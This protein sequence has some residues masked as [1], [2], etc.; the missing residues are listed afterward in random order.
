MAIAI[1]GATFVGLGGP[2]SL[3]AT[4]QCTSTC[5]SQRGAAQWDAVIDWGPGILVRDLAG[6]PICPAE[7]ELSHAALIPRGPF[8]GCVL[9]YRKE[10]ILDPMD[11]NQ[12]APNCGQNSSITWIFDPNGADP[13]ALI[14]LEFDFESDIFCG[15]QSWD[16]WGQLVVAGGVPAGCDTAMPPPFPPQTYRFRPQGLSGQVLTTTEPTPA[17]PTKCPR[18][19]LH[20]SA[21]WVRVGDMAIARYYATVMPLNAD[22]LL[23]SNN[24]VPTPGGTIE[25]GTNLVAGGPP[26]AAQGVGNEFWEVLKARKTTTATEWED[27]FVPISPHVEDPG[28]NYLGN[29]APHF[30]PDVHTAYDVYPRAPAFP[31]AN[32]PNRLLDS[33]PR[34]FQMSNGEILVCGDVDTGGMG[35]PVNAPGSTWVIQPRYSAGNPHWVLADG[36]EPAPPAGESKWHDSWYDSAVLLQLVNAITGQRKPDRV[37]M[38]GGSRDDAGNGTWIVNDEV[39]EFEPTGSSSMTLGNWR[40]KVSPS[41]GEEPQFVGSSVF[42]SFKRVYGNAIIL[43]TGEIFLVGGT[44]EEDGGAGSSHCAGATAPVRPVIYDPGNAPLDRGI[45]YEMPLNVHPRL[46]HSTATLLPDGRVL[47]A[48]G[49]RAKN[50]NGPGDC[51]TNMSAPDPKQTGQLFSPPYLD[52]ASSGFSSRPIVTLDVSTISIGGTFEIEVTRNCN[53][54]IDRVVLLRPGATTHH[55]DNDQ[56]Y[57]ELYYSITTTVPGGPNEEVDTIL[58]TAPGNS[59]LAP[60]GYYMLFAIESDGCIDPATGKEILGHR[61]PSVAQFIRLD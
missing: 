7:F 17:C 30:D 8:A 39:W 57:V 10:I 33:Y 48:G 31:D 20:T 46:Y 19:A 22:Q 45:V 44:S 37:L 28:P 38:F 9:L 54:S 51:P 21:P 50:F 49:K 52:L 42:S 32:Y 2:W 1:C 27:P 5:T 6:N 14:G 29:N 12:C 56:R 36:Q 25:G 47:V 18:A 35:P 40:R 61:V 59:L 4:A 13:A 26:T 53:R 60:Q 3:R 15:G 24:H 34:M 41:N 23:F 55:F 11:P 16:R 58:V 43:P